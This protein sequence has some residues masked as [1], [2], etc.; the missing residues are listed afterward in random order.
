MGAPGRTYNAGSMAGDRELYRVES[1]VNISGG[2]TLDVTDLTAGDFINALEPVFIDFTASPK[3]AYAVRNAK[4]TALATADGTLKKVRVDIYNHLKVGDKLRIP[5]GYGVIAAIDKTNAA[6]HEVEFTEVLAQNVPSGYVLSQVT[7]TAANPATTTTEV[8]REAIV[9]ET[10]APESPATTIASV[11]IC[12]GSGMV[13]PGEGT[14][15]VKLGGATITVTNLD[16]TNENYDLLTISDYTGSLLIGSVLRWTD[17]V[18]TTNPEVV[19]LTRVANRLNYNRKEIAAGVS[20]SALMRAFEIK[21]ADLYVPVSV[22]D[23]ASL[24]PNFIFI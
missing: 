5:G 8:P 6:Y 4:V 13:D 15:E 18:V 2:A 3:K 10:S 24:G 22:E 7:V 20:I 21:E 19:T 1:G 11:K 23:K 9:Y 17:E 12:K 16:A 14:L